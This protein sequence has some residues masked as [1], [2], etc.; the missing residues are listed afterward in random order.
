VKVFEAKTLIDSMEARSKQYQELREKLEQLK[1]ICQNVVN[2]DENL[3][4][5]GATAIKGFYQ[6]QIDV[7]EAWLRLVNKQIA[8]FD[9]IEGTTED[10]NLDGDTVIHLSFLENELP[11]ADNLA[12]EMVSTQRSELDKIFKRIDD[13]VELE[14]FLKDRFEAKMDRAEKLR[15]DT[16]GTMENLDNEL[17]TEYQLTEGDE[18]YAITLFR[19]LQESS[20]QGAQFSPI[21]FNAKAYKTS[22]VY[23]LKKQVEQHAKEYLSF[24]DEQEKFREELKKQEE[25]EHR[26]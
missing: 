25:L 7:L 11:I 5:K 24:K 23:Q 14:A 20:S 9:G 17:K 19:Q 15:R 16:I 8:F 26:P 4:G 21:H 6:A 3:K 1:Q 12:D 18:Q 10:R 2:L 13:L 22:E